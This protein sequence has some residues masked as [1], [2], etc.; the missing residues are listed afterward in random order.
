MARS[1]PRKMESP[2]DNTN[3]PESEMDS[4]SQDL[5][6]VTAYEAAPRLK[7]YIS[8][9]ASC[10]ETICTA[11]AVVEQIQLLIQQNTPDNKIIKYLG[12][13]L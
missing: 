4:F 8:S 10:E 9:M 7:K 5:F 1:N 11:Q 3:S 6:G 12:T 2:E 13:S